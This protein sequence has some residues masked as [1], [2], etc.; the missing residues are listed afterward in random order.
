MMVKS[1]KIFSTKGFTLVELTVS[2]AIMLGI[3]G[4]LLA[5]YPETATRLTLANNNRSI[6]LLIREAQIRGSAIDSGNTEI[7]IASE[8]PLGGYGVYF[9]RDTAGSIILFGDTI[10]SLIPKPFGLAVGN[11]LYENGSPIDETKTITKL[12]RGYLI[13]KLC[14]GTGSPLVF[15][16]NNNNTP[17][18]NSI[19][20]SFTR[21]NPQP[22]IYINGGTPNTN[23]SVACI[24]VES[25][26]APLAGHIRSVEVLNSGMIRAQVTGCE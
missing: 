21:P 25:P 11:G 18:I 13:S 23:F 1:L 17:P 5:N 14:L 26:K 24:E 12:P 2:L 4:I 10:D 9:D 3:M 22:N 20:V 8:S 16:C 19:T 15:N 7:S 6:A